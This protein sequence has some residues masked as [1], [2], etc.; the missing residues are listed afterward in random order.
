MGEHSVC[1]GGARDSRGLAIPAMV[2]V[3]V[4]GGILG[5][6]FAQDELFVLEKL[7]GGVG[8]RHFLDGPRGLT[9]AFHALDFRLWG[10]WAPGYHLT[11]L[12]L[13]AGATWLCT[14]LAYDITS[15]A[16]TAIVC[17]LL[18]AVHPVHVEAVACFAN[19]KD[20][21]AM[22]FV[23][24]ALLLWRKAGA[25]AY[26]GSLLMF[27][28]GLYAKEVAAVGLLPMLF[29]HDL[30]LPRE[31]GGPVGR[32][33]SRSLLRLSPLLVVGMLAACS[34][35][36]DLRGLLDA[37]SMANVTEGQAHGYTEVVATI[38]GALLQ[39]AR[40]LVFPSTLS[41]DYPVEVLSSLWNARALAGMGLLAAW[42]TIGATL[43]RTRSQLAFAMFWVVVMWLPSSNLLP[44]HHFFVAD[45]YLYVPSF[46]FCLAL[47]CLADPL[48]SQSRL[49]L[50]SVAYVTLATVLVAGLFKSLVRSQDWRD[51]DALVMA[52]L[53][54]D[55]D[56]WRLRRDAGSRALLRGDVLAAAAHYERAIELQPNLP[57]LH[58]ERGRVLRSMGDLP[59]A[60]SSV[61]TAIEMRLDRFGRSNALAADAKL[62]IDLGELYEAQGDFKLALS[63]YRAAVKFA[64]TQA[65]GW[66][67]LGRLL[68]RQGE[69]EAATAV[70]RSALVSAPEDPAL[71]N[72][73]AW[74]LVADPTRA[75]RDPKLA[76]ELARS[77][78]EKEPG[79]GGYWTTLGT[80]LFRS[81]D[82]AGACS[83]L[84]RA[85]ELKT[86]VDPRDGFVL[87]MAH[88]QLGQ[89]TKASSWFQRSFESLPEE[90]CEP[91]LEHLRRE[92]EALMSLKR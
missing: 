9:Y 77:A 44:L 72:D 80:A 3:L 90:S 67:R 2:A 60:I 29:V 55:M 7:S 68:T 5:H 92:A 52:G 91:E 65:R 87:S 17:G 24:L 82:W 25:W 79:R 10:R 71:S 57:F 49:R 6:G 45:R 46:G 21:L 36:S 28:L 11:N 50:A 38:A 43:V 88:A 84:E 8:W 47:A 37:A 56:T 20:L 54:D 19:R 85:A 53:R 58:Y 22:V 86:G 39:N 83:A 42:I 66:G 4:F 13:H 16:R 70:Y 15:S 51:H 14:R 64:P 30:L 35:A 74:L 48:L 32:R 41:S 18:F 78:V 1:G 69:I 59:G 76:C 61:R 62:R 75:P 89:M 63:Q 23:A 31:P 26:A 81:G 27:G 33:L 73:L 40:L 12:L 34:W